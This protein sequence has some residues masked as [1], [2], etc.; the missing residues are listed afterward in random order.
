MDGF[1][2]GAGQGRCVAVPGAPGRIGPSASFMTLLRAAAAADPDV[3]AFADQDDVWL[4]DKL[5][6]GVAALQGVAGP[7]LYCSRQILVDHLLRRIGESAPLLQAPGF[8]AALTQNI[9]TGCTVQVNRAAIRLIAGSEPPPT[10]LHD[11]WSYLVVAASG[12]RLIADDTPT[13]LYRQHRGNLVGAPPSL[14]RRAVAAVRRGPGVFMGVL[15][16]HVHALRAQPHLLSQDAAPVLE[17]LHRG[18]HGGPRQR[19]AALRLP[20]LSRQTWQETLLF[21]CW[22]M[23][24]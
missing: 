8:P 13:V 22:F 4:P 21:R 23:I 1:L 3:I 18:L 5:A 20:G 9:A 14:G 16:G 2:A 17:V 12:G 15:R 10:S 7:G 6:R 19:L 24:G 11:W